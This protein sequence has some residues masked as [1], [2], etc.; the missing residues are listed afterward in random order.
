[1]SHSYVTTSLSKHLHIEANQ[2][3]NLNIQIETL[4]L[5]HE[6]LAKQ[7]VAGMERGIEKGGMK[8]QSPSAQREC[9]N[10]Y[11]Q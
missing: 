10:V 7:N 2:I 3:D 8:F 6:T 4:R 9:E 11:V 1:M 5:H